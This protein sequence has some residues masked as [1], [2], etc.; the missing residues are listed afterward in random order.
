[1]SSVTA[2][3]QVDG[4][5][6][7]DV[8]GRQIWHFRAGDP[9]GQPTVL[10]HGVFGAASTWG[11]QISDFADAGLAVFV[12]ERR[13]HGHTPD[14]PGPFGYADMVAETIAYLEQ[15][16]RVPAHLVG[17][18]DGGVI[19]L[20]VARERPDLVRR[21]VMVASYIS[22]EGEVP[23]EFFDMIRSRHPATVEFLR[24]DYALTSPDGAEHFEI[25][26]DKTLAM[27]DS[28]P[29]R[30]FDEF[31][32]VTTPTLVLAADNGAARVE[33]A[34]ALSRALPNGRLAVLPGTHILPVESPEV[35]NPLVIS[36]LTAEPPARWTPHH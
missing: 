14:Q 31:A 36:F 15:A 11:A 25:V 32:G 30:R 7:V 6:Y 1:M 12:P 10:L 20:L 33:H 24:S 22:R 35:F 23:G 26:Y 28:E 21:V 2:G 9:A 4:G 8:G 16:V 19:A 13:G 17:W 5:V 18:S 3:E 27:I 34:L 29:D